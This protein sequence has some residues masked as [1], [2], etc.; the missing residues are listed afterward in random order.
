[1]GR[2]IGR[3]YPELVLTCQEFVRRCRAAGLNV[4][5]TETTRSQAEQDSL[6]AQGRTEPGAVI[7]NAPYPKS[8]HNW[9]VAF[10]FC[11]NVKGREY[12]DSDGFFRACGEIGEGLGLT[13]GGRWTKFPDKP[14]L[15]LK[16]LMPGS[17]TKWLIQT[18]GTPEAFFETWRETDGKPPAPEP[19][20]EEMTQ[21]QFSQ[22]MGAYLAD[23]AK[24]PPSDWSA[25]GRTWAEENGIL[26]GDE[27]GNLDYKGFVTREQLAIVMQRMSSFLERKE[28][29]ER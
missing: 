7:T 28:A 4:L 9:G 2:G 29:K 20:E 18:Y 27:A 6:Y 1:M 14:H 12:Y 26:K 21:A 3:L 16:R 13:C 22:M 19:E 5:V 25:E 23:L 10:D 11:R 8:A 17:S 24:Q 15:E